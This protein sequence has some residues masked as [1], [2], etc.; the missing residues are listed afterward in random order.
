MKNKS[1]VLT[2][3]ELALNALHEI[4]EKGIKPKDAIEDMSAGLDIRERSFLMDLVYGVLRRRYTLDW[5]FGEFLKKPA[6]LSPHTLNNLRLAAYQILFTR[7]PEWAAVN[8]A[9]EI[10]KKKGRPEVINAVLR[11]LLRKPSQLRINLDEVRKK[12]PVQHIALATSHPQWM[13]KRWVNRFGEK[14]ALELTE[15]NNRVPPF[16]LRVN[17]LKVTRHDMIRRLSDRGIH[18]KPTSF[19]PDGITMDYFRLLREFPEFRDFLIVQDEAAQLVTYLLDPRPG[20]KVLDAC[21][22]PG[23]KTTH[24]AQLMHDNGEIVAVDHDE[25]RVEKL[26][27][28]VSRMKLKSIQIIQA[29]LAD[30]FGSGSLFDR[31]LL[32]APCSSLGV[33]RRNPDIKYR[34]SRRDITTFKEKQR[35]MLRDVSRLLRPGGILVYSVCSTEP[36]EGEDVIKE[37]LKDLENFYIIETVF[38]FLREHMKTGFF[39]TYPHTSGMDGFFG[40]RLCRKV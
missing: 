30:L 22:A 15:A 27:E 8:E 16:T 38:P 32:D 36:E 39:R 40:A 3:R 29:D 5:S 1:F 23:G 21:A 7:V 24:I 13:V 37:F 19:S 35:V 34:H 25:R 28:N 31:I 12:G 2:T 6:G 10:E 9:V 11:N 20:E 14:E 18:A 33:I 4:A 17:T 26:R